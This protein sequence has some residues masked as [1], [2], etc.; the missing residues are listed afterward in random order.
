[1]IIREVWNDSHK[2]EFD[3]WIDYHSPSHF[4]TLE[5]AVRNADNVINNYLR[6]QEIRFS[7]LEDDELPCIY[8]VELDDNNTIFD[9]LRMYDL[10][11]NLIQD[12]EQYERDR[13]KQFGD[14]Y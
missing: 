10:E 6:Q 11:G 7:D 1:M 4:K 13:Y 12:Y 5:Q 3:V 8:E 9:T 14:V 2:I